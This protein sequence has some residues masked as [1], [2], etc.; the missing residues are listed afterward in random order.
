M[1]PRDM[2][3]AAW[4]LEIRM[5][6]MAD[7]AAAWLLEIHMDSMADLAGTRWP[8]AAIQEQ[9]TVV[10]IPTATWVAVA[11]ALL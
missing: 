5:D 3:L 2:G 6:L 9:T 7:L 10:P 4:L 8:P 11:M 1:L